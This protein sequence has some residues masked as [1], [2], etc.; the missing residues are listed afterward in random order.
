MSKA[1]EA[2]VLVNE[3]LLHSLITHASLGKALSQVF[4]DNYSELTRR[5]T[6]KPPVDYELLKELSEAFKYANSRLPRR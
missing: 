4:S 2:K 1:L 5:L 3:A 6:L